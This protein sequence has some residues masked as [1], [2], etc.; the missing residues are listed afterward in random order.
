MI[1][2]RQGS[3][4]E[5]IIKRKEEVEQVSSISEGEQFR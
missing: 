1:S 5:A 2:K 4:V 3:A